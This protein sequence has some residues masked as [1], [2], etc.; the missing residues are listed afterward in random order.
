MHWLSTTHGPLTCSIRFVLSASRSV[1][2]ILLQSGERISHVG[3]ES[4]QIVVAMVD[5][6]LRGFG[7]IHLHAQPRCNV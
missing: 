6:W 3:V 7:S 1:L 4:A 2:E 5:G